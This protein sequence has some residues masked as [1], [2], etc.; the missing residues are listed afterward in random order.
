MQVPLEISYRDVQKTDAVEDLIYE[1]AD[2]LERVC[3]Y[4]MSCRVAVEQPHKH[5]RTGKHYRVRIDLTVP[6]NHELVVTR[7]SGDSEAVKPIHAVLRS[8]FNAARRKLEKLVDQQRGE[9]KSHPQQES[10]VVV[11]KLFRDSGYGFLK[12]TDGR[13]IYFH[14]NSVL[15][16]DFD[17]LEIGTVVRFVEEEGEKGAQASTVQIVDKPGVRITATPALE[18]PLGWQP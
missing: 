16:N 1:E 12:A 10:D 14:R 13:E 11:Y 4:I 3:D 5:Q 6:P 8:T 7:D 18:P 2:K 15:N 17:R 9:V